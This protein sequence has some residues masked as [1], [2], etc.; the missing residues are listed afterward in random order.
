VV[1]NKGVEEDKVS[2]AGKFDR[3]TTEDVPDTQRRAPMVCVGTLATSM[4]DVALKESMSFVAGV[5]LLGD[6]FVAC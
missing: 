4:E 3:K 5:V 6:Q 1:N 2:V